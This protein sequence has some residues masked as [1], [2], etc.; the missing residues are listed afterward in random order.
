MSSDFTPRSVLHALAPIGMATAQVESLSS[1]F[2]RLANSHSCSSLDLAQFVIDRIA[3]DRWATCL[4]VEGK[5]RFLWYERSISGL[6][7][8]AQLW[9]QTLSTLTTVPFLHR[10]TL[11]PLQSVTASRGMVSNQERWCP[12]CLQEDLAQGRA[13]YFRLAWDVGPNKICGKHQTELMEHCPHCKKSR[14]RHSASYVVPG[15]CTACGAFLGVSDSPCAAVAHEGDIER[16]NEIEDLLAASSGADISADLEALHK[17]IETLAERLDN[18]VGAHFAKRIGVRKSTVHH[19][20]HSRAPLTLDALMQVSMQCGVRLL[21]LVQGSLEGWTSLA[22]VEADNDSRSKSNNHS[23]KARRLHDWGDVRA[24]LRKELD[25]QESPKSVAEI[26]RKLAI[27]KRALYLNAKQET[28][29]LGARYVEHR[30]ERAEQKRA[31]HHRV[32]E[33]VCESIRQSG[34]GIALRLVS[35]LVDKRVLTGTPNL[36]N[37][38][39]RIASNTSVSRASRA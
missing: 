32:L 7:S 12:R 13:P 14:V 4:G 15:W 26:A 17:A 3:P 1:Y 28:R 31:E 22:V 23:G 20:K 11:A 9:A 5:S 34:Q 30:H 35:S 37:K 27:N 36:Y 25:S 38:L 39:S 24:Y 19:W 8:S 6:G 18:G 2:C 10:L 29:Q 33:Q 16:T 21:D